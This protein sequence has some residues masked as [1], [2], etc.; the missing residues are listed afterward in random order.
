LR[1]TEGVDLNKV[2]AGFS[3]PLVQIFSGTI[4]DCVALGLLERDGNVIRLT[5][6][7]RLLS[8]EVFE[9]FIGTADAA[10]TKS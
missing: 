10:L 8:N 7:G 2:A 3:E 4:L 6:R 9:R 1:L 5:R